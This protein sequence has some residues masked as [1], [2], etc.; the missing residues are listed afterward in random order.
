MGDGRTGVTTPQPDHL[1][2]YRNEPRSGGDPDDHTVREHGYGDAEDDADTCRYG[3][4]YPVPG[5]IR[6]CRRGS[7]PAS[8]DVTQA[9]RVPAVEDGAG[10]NMPGQV[11]QPGGGGQGEY[12][13]GDR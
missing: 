4:R 6:S 8:P 7:C 3:S 1:G 11:H 5:Q 10:V 13:G 9:E 12:G 2:R